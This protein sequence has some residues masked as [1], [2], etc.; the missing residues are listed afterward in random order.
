MLRALVARLALAV[1]VV[2]LVFVVVL[3]V[4]LAGAAS[5][6]ALLVGVAATAVVDIGG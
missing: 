1:A 6:D 3:R 4:V 5:L 2:V